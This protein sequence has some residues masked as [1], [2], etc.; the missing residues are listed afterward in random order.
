MPRAHSLADVEV[1][2]EDAAE[3]AVG[4]KD[5]SRSPPAPEAILL[6]QVRKSTAHHR[7]PPGLARRPLPLEAIDSA[8]PGAAPAVAQRPDGLLC[9][10][11]QLPK[12]ECQV[13]RSK[14][15]GGYGARH[16]RSYQK[17]AYDARRC[18]FTRRCSLCRTTQ[19]RGSSVPG[20]NHLPLSRSGSDRGVDRHGPARTPSAL[21]SEGTRP[22]MEAVARPC[23]R[24]SLRTP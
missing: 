23:R 5:G 20:S 17:P 9:A 11:R 24:T 7:P 22:R 3:I 13:R 16:D 8:V 15:V 19:I 4:E 10:P 14:V 6:P 21:E 12:G 1:L 2:A 18:A